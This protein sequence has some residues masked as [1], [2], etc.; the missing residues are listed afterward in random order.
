[1]LAR[2]QN[3]RC[4][5]CGALINPGELTQIDHHVPLSKGGTNAVSNLRWMHDTCNRDKADRLG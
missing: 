2:R 1:M 3:G 4:A 5:R